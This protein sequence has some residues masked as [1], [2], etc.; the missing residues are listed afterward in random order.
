MR[1]T[2]YA[3]ACFR[4]DA[5]GLSV[6]T[7]SYTPGPKPGSG[8]DPVDEPADLVIMSSSTDTFHSD[9]SHV[10]GEPVVV[11][12]LTVPPA[13]LTVKGVEIRAFPAMESLSFDFQG[14]FGRHPD[15][16]ALYLFTL[17]GLR[18]LHL[19][20]TGNPVPAEHLDA[21]RGNVDIMLALAGAHATIAFEDLDAAITAINPR[22]VIPMHY[23]SPRGWLQIEPVEA[24][25]SRYPAEMVTRVGTPTLELTRDT[26]PPDR[27][28][29]VLDQSR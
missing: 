6:I 29:F 11:D 16:N 18:V 23:Y 5:D 24:F 9:P 28:I 26:L 15:A 2:F 4:F 10:R 1:I 3:H 19:G 7:D 22:V 21:L 20:D 8:F 12:A 25:L 13:G 27:H 17:G 14:E